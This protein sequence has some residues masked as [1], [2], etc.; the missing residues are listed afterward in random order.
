[1]ADLISEIV[2]Q[3]ALE[4]VSKLTAL[5]EKATGQ[6]ELA[7]VSGAELN[8]TLT[9]NSAKEA[10]SAIN[11]L[12]NTTTKLIETESE[13]LNIERQLKAEGEKMAANVKVTSNAIEQAAAKYKMFSNSQ[14]ELAQYIMETDRRLAEIKDALKN[15]DKSASNYTQ[16]TANLKIE[17]AKLKAELSEATKELKRTVTEQKF[18]DDSMKGMSVRLLQLKDLYS[19]FTE[20]ERNSEFGQT[21]SQGINELDEKLK[22]LDKSIGDNQRSVGEYEVA[23]KSLRSQ[24]MDIVFFL[25]LANYHRNIRDYV[26]IKGY[27]NR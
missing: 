1:M 26:L 19:Q 17:Q 10:S 21:I 11:N 13:R 23:G 16:A 8:K 6:M 3:E 25:V 2:S 14:K 5:L 7:I 18:A 4:Q 27:V 22:G 20:T 24:I 9:G 12:N 15:A